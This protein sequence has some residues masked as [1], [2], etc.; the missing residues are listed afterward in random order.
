MSIS[1]RTVTVAEATKTKEE[2][3][4]C[5]KEL[6]AMVKRLSA[7]KRQLIA[8]KEYIEVAV[9]DALATQLIFSPSKIAESKIAESKIID[10]RV[11]L[12]KHRG[13][14]ISSQ[15]ARLLS[16]I[17][18]GPYNSLFIMMDGTVKGIGSNTYYNTIGTSSAI[19]EIKIPTEVDLSI[20]EDGDIPIS[21][22]S[23]RY[24][25]LVLTNSGKVI[26]FGNNERYQMG[27][28]DDSG[29]PIVLAG[30]N[31]SQ[32][33]YTNHR[34]GPKNNK[35]I[36]I[37]AGVYYSII[38]DEYGTVYGFGRNVIG[39][40]GFSIDDEI[41]VPRKIAIAANPK[42]TAVSTYDE[43]S[44]ILD[45]DGIV[46]SFG[47]NRYGQLGRTLVGRTS[48]RTPEQIDT[49]N[50]NS[51]RIVAISTGLYHSL[52]LDEQ[53]KVYSFGHN[54]FGELGQGTTNLDPM[55]I[56]TK[57]TKG[58]IEH[59][60]IVAIAASKY[61]SL[62]LDV[63]G[64]VYSCGKA[65]G[66]LHLL[67]D[68]TWIPALGRIRGVDYKDITN[69]RPGTAGGRAMP[70]L[71]VM[72]ST[73]INS[74]AVSIF[75]GLAQHY[76]DD[77]PYSL[78]HLSNGEIRG[79]GSHPDI[80][81]L[82]GKS[83]WVDTGK[84]KSI[85]KDFGVYNHLKLSPA[86]KSGG[87]HQTPIFN[88]TQILSGSE[89]SNDRNDSERIESTD[90]DKEVFNGV[91][92][93]GT[94]QFLIGVN[95]ILTHPN[96]ISETN[97][98]GL[99]NTNP[100]NLV[101]SPRV[102]LEPR[103][104]N[105]AARSEYEAARLGWS[106]SSFYKTTPYGHHVWPSIDSNDSWT[107]KTSKITPEEPEKWLQ[108][109]L[110]NLYKVV[111]VVVQARGEGNDNKIRYVKTFTVKA[112]V[113]RDIKVDNGHTFNAVDAGI[114]KKTNKSDR[115]KKAYIMFQTPITTQYISVFPKTWHDNEN[116][117]NGSTADAHI[118]IRLGVIVSQSP[119][120]R[121]YNIID[122][123]TNS[124]QFNELKII[125]NVETGATTGGR[126]SI[127]TSIDDPF[128]TPTLITLTLETGHNI[129][130][131]DGDMAPSGNLY[132]ALTYR[133]NFPVPSD[134]KKFYMLFNISETNFIYDNSLVII[135]KDAAIPPNKVIASYR[136][137]DAYTPGLK[138]ALSTG[139]LKGLL[140]QGN[141]NITG[142]V[143]SNSIGKVI[144]S[145]MKD[146][147]YSTLQPD[148]QKIRGFGL[149]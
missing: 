75:T 13:I 133:K 144:P 95:S 7:M 100:Q 143:S 146:Y 98:L 39:Q 120:S 46:Y 88:S 73:G 22:A 42:I 149:D 103:N 59:K 123:K 51:N 130:S 136:R 19:D 58:D 113:N 20:I 81:E 72:D 134:D 118:A 31:I 82:D 97:N 53:G 26:A 61:Y 52:V 79:Y 3:G 65:S 110:K 36:A 76:P 56:P 9:K 106:W 64:T 83:T 135:T 114:G 11:K 128:P 40:L 90:N 60:T 15:A 142:A 68:N 125:K 41:K 25:S 132:I 127:K 87:G 77:E 45:S 115:D 70:L 8:Q 116:D 74:S 112:G 111:G 66:S 17:S 93:T 117:S 102:D 129:V 92:I 91:D 109:N 148:L 34:D 49:D 28:A 16:Y 43:H 147:N 122:V 54:Y 94:K 145:D 96:N 71:R 38:L 48:D 141:E 86:I 89:L 78:V 6:H 84:D 126:V 69:S 101:I 21:V 23:G 35:I 85:V 121:P 107:P 105:T 104:S 5:R 139:V 80:N 1:S 124:R 12:Y 2:V 32:E 4:N 67:D 47:N 99:S 50:I 33:I 18:C 37:S 108:L 138:H 10:Y 137:V 57:I 27:I 119:L 44:L 30:K 131:I 62:V 140:M 14:I 29:N 55:Y 24:H 63:K